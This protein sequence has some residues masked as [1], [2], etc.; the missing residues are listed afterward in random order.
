MPQFKLPLWPVQVSQPDDFTIS[1]L[2]SPF[3]A[4]YVVHNFSRDFRARLQ[5]L[6][7]KSH[8]SKEGHIYSKPISAPSCESANY[9]TAFQRWKDVLAGLRL[10]VTQHS[11]SDQTETNSYKL[12]KEWWD[13]NAYDSEV[14]V[15]IREW[16]EQAARLLLDTEIR[17]RLVSSRYNLLLFD[18]WRAE[19]CYEPPRE[20]DLFSERMMA[21]AEAACHRLAA[22]SLAT[23]L[24]RNS[25][26]ELQHDSPDRE[27]PDQPQQLLHEVKSPMTAGIH[28]CSWLDPDDDALSS[29]YFLWDR[30]ESRT[31][32]TRGLVSP[33]YIAISHTWGRWRKTP[34][35]DVLVQG[36]PWQ[37]P[38]NTLFEAVSLPALLALVP[39]PARYIWFDLVCIPQDMSH[40]VLGPRAKVEIAN[41]ATIFKSASLACAWFNWVPSW[42]G[43]QN[44]IEWLSL[45]YVDINGPTTCNL[46]SLLEIAKGRAEEA[47]NLLLVPQQRF[48]EEHEITGDSQPSSWFTSLWT[49]QEVC[50]RPDM[51]LCDKDWRAL[52]CRPAFSVPIDHIIALWVSVEEAIR[53]HQDVWPSGAREIRTLLTHTGM[54]ELPRMSQLTVLMLGNQRYCEDRR[55]E[56]IMSVVGVKDWFMRSYGPENLQDSV[57]RRYPFAFVEELRQKLKGQFFS[58]ADLLF[59][60]V[61]AF[62]TLLPFSE[63]SISSRK[64]TSGPL[65]LDDHPSVATWKLYPDGRVLLPEVG[66]IAAYPRRFERNEYARVL[67]PKGT[68]NLPQSVLEEVELNEF[69][70]SFLREKEK[71]AVCLLTTGK[72]RVNGFILMEDGLHKDITYPPLAQSTKL[73][74][75]VAVFFFNSNDDDH[76]SLRQGEQYQ[77]PISEKVHWMVL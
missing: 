63:K 59:R 29:P 12:L 23:I 70:A 73:F 16:I 10:P 28:P 2:E 60:E 39:F 71:Y 27:L 52:T 26:L 47:T 67:I 15:H 3:Q 44:A 43:L 18:L 51:L 24:S 65:D 48:G 66:V 37:V 22:N 4:H 42:D 62:G 38:Q 77:L 61:N 1:R 54:V 34:S 19:F 35:S 30:L 8:Q 5:T 49:L 75:K 56:A 25:G 72:S 40:P 32:V 45:V 50:L 6:S 31:V 46:E 14:T 76:K 9:G 33:K 58:S 36:V 57:L 55:A 20:N 21:A 11:F 69:L 64:V 17:P 74:R 13:N 41:Q 68:P 53:P 7:M